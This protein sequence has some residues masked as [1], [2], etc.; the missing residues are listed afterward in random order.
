MDQ[1]EIDILNDMYDFESDFDQEEKWDGEYFLGIYVCRKDIQM[2]NSGERLVNDSNRLY[3]G[4]TISPKLFFKY[5]NK[6]VQKYL[7]STIKYCPY[8]KYY[9]LNISIMKLD[10]THDGLCLVTIKTYWLKIIQRHWK[11]IM[12]RRKEIIEKMN[13]FSY[14]KKRELGKYDRLNMPSFIGMLNIYSKKRI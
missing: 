12:K 14:I 6:Y 7:Y 13:R 2:L 3:L 5:E 1:S 10:I 8:A 11:K 9:R 4:M